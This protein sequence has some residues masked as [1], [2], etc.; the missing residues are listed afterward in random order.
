LQ[1]QKICTLSLGDKRKVM[2]GSTAIGSHI[3]VLIDEPFDGL[4][5]AGKRRMHNFIKSLIDQ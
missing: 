5:V 3:V 1:D 4:D 2:V